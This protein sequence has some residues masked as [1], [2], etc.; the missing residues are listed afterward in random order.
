[1]M[2]GA[3]PKFI[4]GLIA[5]VLLAVMAGVGYRLYERYVADYTVQREDDGRILTRVIDARLAASAD[6]RVSRLSGTIQAVSSDQ[7]MGG[8]LSSSLVFKA[9]FE[10]G[11]FVDLAKLD[12]GDF[13]WDEKGKTLLVTV[14]DVRPEAPNIDET[15]TTV[16]RTTGIFVTRDAM[17]ALRKRAS[18][19]AQRV[20]GEEAVKPA[21]LAVARAN[22]R[23]AIT[24]LFARPLRIAGLDMKVQVRFAGEP[25]L[26]AEQMDRSRSLAEIYGQ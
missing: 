10:V 16:D 12:R 15:K 11:Y 8:L 19:N 20:A 6:L 21:R 14:P 13:F 4:S 1:M 9:P 17:A 23:K 24:E 5:I 25:N 3:L 2:G 18:L 26:D 22:G 7:R